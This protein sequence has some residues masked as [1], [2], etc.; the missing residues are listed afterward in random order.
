[1]NP[2]VSVI[3]PTYNRCNLLIEAVDSVLSQTYDNYELIVVDD[4]STDETPSLMPDYNPRIRYIWQDNQG[5]SAARNRGMA[6]ARGEYIAFLD[7]DDL[8]L[9]EKL[10]FQVPILQENGEIGLVFC[11]AQRIDAD[12]I[13][14]PGV[15]LS[16]KRCGN[17]MSL[18]DV[19]SGNPFP[20][21]SVLLRR[22]FIDVTGGFDT[23][24]RY[25]EDWD[26]WLR[27]VTE[28]K[29]SCL[30]NILASIRVHADGQWFFPKHDVAQRLLDDH[31]KIIQGV[32]D[33]TPVIGVEAPTLQSEMIAKE[34]V[35]AAW[36]NYVFSDYQLAR[37]QMEKAIELDRDTWLNCASIEKGIIGKA[38]VMG[39]MK[40]N[41][42]K[43]PRQ[44]VK[45]VLIQLPTV[46]AHCASHPNKLIGRVEIEIGHYWYSIGENKQARQ[47]LLKGVQY[48]PNWV[49]NPGTVV[50]LLES[51]FGASF[52]SSLRR[53]MQIIRSDG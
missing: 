26:L 51:Y 9:P 36:T 11:L 1:M 12:G 53:L 18:L 32:F 13:I 15:P 46:L 3:I 10:S 17:V 7:S 44:F 14:I 40:P 52:V 50:A 27:L 16:Y 48:D 45:N 42:K 22:E 24:I 35:G 23:E 29:F 33:R 19:L 39:Q 47:H 2:T 41:E 28:T 30:P 38:L 6:L 34:Y 31:L 4:G 8:W 5:E 49:R 25:G 43:A 21:C 37:A 20:P